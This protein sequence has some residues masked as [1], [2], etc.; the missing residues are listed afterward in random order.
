LGLD[1][2]G[3]P[4][5]LLNYSSSVIPII[6]SA[7]LCSILERRLNAWLPSAIKNFF[8]PLLC[9]MVITPVT[10]LLV[11]PLSTWISELIAAGY[12]WLYQAVP[13]FAGAVM[14]GFWQ[15]FVMFGLH[16]GLVP[17]CINNFTV[18]GYDTMIPLLM[19]AIMAQVGAALG[20]FLCERDAQKKVVAGSAALT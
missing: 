6:F 1:F 11:G 9:L 2:L 5:T 17:L 20:V 12:L 15:I 8:T 19:P 16:W 4:V 10:F 13:A 3:I 18:L 7:W 14:G